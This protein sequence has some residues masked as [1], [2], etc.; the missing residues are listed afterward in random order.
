M[1][2]A[3]S[4][5]CDPYTHDSWEDEISIASSALRGFFLDLLL[6]KGFEF[7]ATRHAHR[8]EP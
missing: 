5:R 6:E 1:C 3:G 2:T 4:F 7:R 8:V